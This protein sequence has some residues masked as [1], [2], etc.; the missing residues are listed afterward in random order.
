MAVIAGVAVTVAAVA[1]VGG[2]D[3]G[4]WVIIAVV[5]ERLGARLT[6]RCQLLGS[7]G[8]FRALRRRK[9]LNIKFWTS[10][11]GSVGSKLRDPAGARVLRRRSSLPSLYEAHSRRLLFSCARPFRTWG[12][13]GIRHYFVGHDMDCCRFALPI[14]G[15]GS[16]R[17]RENSDHRRRRV[18]CRRRSPFGDFRKLGCYGNAG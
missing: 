4:L 15:D 13:I 3:W 7:L 11:R 6:T 1:A 16:G 9:I 17:I 14:D 18:R 8:S 5:S 10:H 12:D 2:V